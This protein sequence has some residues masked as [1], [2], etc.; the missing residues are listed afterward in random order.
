M[1]EHSFEIR[2]VAA[3][4]ALFLAGCALLPVLLRMAADQRSDAIGDG[5]VTTVV[6]VG[7]S[8]QRDHYPADP[9]QS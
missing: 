3:F 6:Y 7:E 9:D 4:I 8:G 5:H 1:S 2:A